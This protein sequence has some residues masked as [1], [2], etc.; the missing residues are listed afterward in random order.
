MDDEGKL[1]KIAGGKYNAANKTFT[2]DLPHLSLYV[3][4]YD[5]VAAWVNPFTDVFETDWF[6]ENVCFAA[7][8][9][10]VL[11]GGTSATTFAP[12][13][14]LTRAMAYTILARMAGETIS[15]A[16]WIVDATAWAVETGISDGTN[17]TENITRGMLATML[18]RFA[19]VGEDGWDGEAMEWSAARGIISDGRP[20]DTATRAE[21]AAVISRFCA[22]PPSLRATPP[23]FRT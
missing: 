7:T 5:E 21:M 23:S 3:I 13:A 10:P 19:G 8:H 6:Y 16:S 22:T 11:M 15:G 2:F 4:G 14:P 1:E 9:D 17:P 12:N 20:E 18:Y